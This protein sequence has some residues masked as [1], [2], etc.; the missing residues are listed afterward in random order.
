MLCNGKLFFVTIRKRSLTLVMSGTT[1]ITSHSLIGTF[2]L[3]DFVETL[4]CG[5]SNGFRQTLLEI[6]HEVPIPCD[7]HSRPTVTNG[8]EKYKYVQSDK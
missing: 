4:V 2:L 5:S 6:L 1:A 8:G 7:I 3:L